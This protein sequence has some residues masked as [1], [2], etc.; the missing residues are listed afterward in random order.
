[1]PKFLPYLMYLMYEPVHTTGHS[2]DRF[3]I[4]EKTILDIISHNKKNLSW[5]QGINDFTDLTEDEFRS[6]RLM[7][8]QN[9]SATH[10]LK[11]K[12]NLKL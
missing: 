5:T 9:C 11:V 4:F 12:G 3:K 2:K 10:G 8:P 7:A 1:M 6:L